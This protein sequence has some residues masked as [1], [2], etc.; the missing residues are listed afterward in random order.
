MIN[1]TISKANA[2]KAILAKIIAKDNKCGKK[3][4]E[5]PKQSMPTIPQHTKKIAA[6]IP[7]P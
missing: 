1:S 7:N 6:S 5:N 2:S 3:V 4:R